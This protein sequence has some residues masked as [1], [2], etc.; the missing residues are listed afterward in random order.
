L[1]FYQQAL[2]PDPAAGNALLA[3]L[4]D[5]VAAEVGQ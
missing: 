3:V 2:V 5:A 1:R 4:A